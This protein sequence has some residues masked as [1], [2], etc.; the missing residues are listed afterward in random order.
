ME[1]SY[2]FGGGTTT[3]IH[4][5]DNVGKVPFPVLYEIALKEARKIHR[6][7]VE[8]AVVIDENGIVSHYTGDRDEV[9]LPR[10]VLQY[11]RII[12]HNHPDE[13]NIPTTFT[14]ADIYNLFHH[15]L[16][17]IIVCG[18]GDYFYM[19]KG[20]C[21]LLSRIILD[22]VK[23]IY[24]NVEKLQF[25]KHFGE[26]NT[27]LKGVKAEYRQYMADVASEYHS[28]LLK[29]ASEKRICYGRAKL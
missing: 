25:K 10:S 11:A 22:D 16:D 13:H 4:Q 28:G 27:S 23:R 17:G 2:F 14:S 15:N 19:K 18:Y 29:Y 21:C 12:V 24:K 8:H 1:N 20:S 6:E 26:H 3:E 5:M 7:K 9:G